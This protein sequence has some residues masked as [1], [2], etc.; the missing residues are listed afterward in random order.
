MVGPLSL[1]NRVMSFLLY[2]H[3]HTYTTY[4]HIHTQP[5]LHTHKCVPSQLQSRAALCDP[6]G[7]SPPGSSVHGISQAR[8]LEWAAISSSR[9]SSRPRDGT[10]N[11]LCL[12]HW[13]GGFF[14]TSTTWVDPPPP[15]LTH[16][17]THTHIY[18]HTYIPMHIRTRM[19]MYLHT[20]VH[21]YIRTNLFLRRTLTVTRSRRTSQPQGGCR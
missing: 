8:I 2:I 10:R 1:Q 4:M 15:P 16:T 13:Q 17:Y 19:H 12:L 5:Y 14:S 18:L 11:P 7:C 21:T 9:E 6:M 20:R 3:K